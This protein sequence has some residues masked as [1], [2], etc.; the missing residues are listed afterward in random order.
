MGLQNG[1]SSSLK[2]KFGMSVLNGLPYL[3]DTSTSGY[4]GSEIIV[5][6]EREYSN[7]AENHQTIV[8]NRIQEALVLAQYTRTTKKL[9]SLGKHLSLTLI[10]DRLC[11]LTFLAYSFY[12]H[13]SL[14]KERSICDE[15]MLR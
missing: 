4:Y 14:Y 1:E 6:A 2:Q 10:N 8:R 13:A 3:R 15:E 9:R 11:S 7:T 12:N 5:V